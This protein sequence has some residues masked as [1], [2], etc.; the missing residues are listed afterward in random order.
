MSFCQFCCEV[1]KTEGVLFICVPKE[2]GKRKLWEK[3]LE[4]SLAPNGRIC[5][6]HFKASDFY[7]ETKTKTERKRRRLLP[8]ALPRQ[9]NLKPGYSNANTQTEEKVINRTT[10]MG[11]EIMRKKISSME[12]EMHSLR[13][14]LEQYQT[15]EKSLG[16]IFT[17][18]QIKILKS[19]GKR[20]TFNATDMSAAICLHSVGPRTYKHLYEKGFPLPSRATIFRWLADVKIN[21]GTLDVV[22]DLMENEEMCLA[23]KLCV[24]S[25][26]KIQLAAAFDINGSEDALNERN[27]YVQLATVRGLK[28][29][30]KQPVYFGFNTLMDVDS[31]NTIIMKLHKINYPVVAVVSDLSPENQSLWRELGI[32]ETNKSWFSHPA[33]EQLK[34]FVFSDTTQLIKLIHNHYIDVGL[35]IN[36][37]KLTKTTVQQT[38]RH[39]ARPDVSIKLRINEN[40]L[41][42][43]S[44]TKQKDTL[45]TQL[46]SRTTARSI[47]RCHELGYA[48]N[49]AC[50]TADFFELFND[51]FD[52]FNSNRLNF[53]DSSEAYGKQIENQQCTLARMSEIMRTEMTESGD[54]LTFQ[55]GILINNAS[56]D[57]LYEYLSE[58]YDMIH[59]LTSRLSQENVESFFGSMRSIGHGGQYDHPTPLQFRDKIRKYIEGMI[60]LD[61]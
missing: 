25:I 38:M 47:R 1:V 46:F 52:V 43:C 24:L 41:K 61:Q 28:K 7:G 45:A 8:N 44:L 60:K 58:K 54:K 12:K 42:V 51:W 26:D 37:H 49:N 22:L 59:I 20:S 4:C 9:P 14:Q 3:S 18:T 55:M 17:E 27:N 15:L 2:D 10:L 50:E 32:S 35:D 30:W 56:L 36:G 31:L 23:D 57:G 19:G 40:H 21:A 33:D 5:D 6:T 34:I 16:N 39:C 29:A 48:I 11:N 53:P 13:Q